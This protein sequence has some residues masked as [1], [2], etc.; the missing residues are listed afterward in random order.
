MNLFEE[1]LF[2][3]TQD[4][5][6]IVEF[7]K[8]LTEKSLEISEEDAKSIKIANL[9][10]QVARLSEMNMNVGNKLI[11]LQDHHKA[12]VAFVHE[13]LMKIEAKQK[14]NETNNSNN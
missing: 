13:G 9:Y 3:K 8:L 10:G 11:A 5:L 12:F 6:D 4:L 14:K 2:N 7:E 1:N